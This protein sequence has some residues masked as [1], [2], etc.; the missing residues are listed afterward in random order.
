MSH[1]YPAGTFG[2]ALAVALPLTALAQDLGPQDR[3]PLDQLAVQGEYIVE[4][5]PSALPQPTGLLES[6][7]ARRVRSAAGF[8]LIRQSGNESLGQ[9]GDLARLERLDGVRSVRPN[10]VNQL[11]YRPDDPDLARLWMVPAIN[12]MPAWSAH[13][14][15]S[16]IVVAVIDS[17][18][19]LAHEDLADHI[20]QNPGETPGDGIDNDQ[21]GFVDDVAGW[22]FGDGD[23]DPTPLLACSGKGASGGGHG[24]HVAGTIG[25][26]GGNGRGVIGVAPRVKIMALKVAR[27]DLPCTA[28]GTFARYAALEYAI[29]NGAKIV[30]MSLSGPQRDSLDL[31]LLELAAENDVLVVVSAANDGL[32]NDAAGPYGAAFVRTGDD[33]KPVIVAGALAP[34]FPS[35]WDTATMIAVAATEETPPGQPAAFV[36]AWREGLAWNTRID[37]LAYDTKGGIDFSQATM[38]PVAAGALPI[39]SNWGKRKVHVAAP[40]HRIF[41]TVPGVEGDAFTSAYASTSGTSMATPAVAGAAAVLWSAFPEMTAVDVKRRLIATSAPAPSLE[42]RVFSG[43]Q[44]DLYAALCGPGAPRVLEGCAGAAAP[45]PATDPAN[46]APIV[47]APAVA[48][49]APTT[50]TQATVAAPAAGVVPGTERDAEGSTTGASGPVNLNELL[51]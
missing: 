48:S 45:A 22:D 40:G 6:F 1:S 20:W 27:A 16:E 8:A 18:V 23:A 2:A 10:F 30:N 5:A 49:P 17:G 21:N 37:G 38:T 43:G 46:A 15:A 13:H 14:D 34:K 33:G 25:A 44:I 29:K 31:K 12:A 35:S 26:I 4:Y 3:L 42:T 28:V 47:A 32:D 50:Q 36:E 39:G 41:S 51:E 7:G 24:S 9:A 11:D 19:F